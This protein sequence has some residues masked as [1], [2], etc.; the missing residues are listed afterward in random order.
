MGITAFDY[1]QSRERE[2]VYAAKRDGRPLGMTSGKYSV[3]SMSLKMLRDSWD[4]LS[5]Q[6]TATGLGSYGDA[7]FT[8]I[9]QYIEPLQ[10]PI[11]VTCVGCRIKG[12]KP[13]NEEGTEALMTELDIQ[14]LEI[15]EN[16]KPL[17]SLVR[18]V[19]L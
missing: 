6:L 17:A 15:L 18:A 5:T 7:E 13:S 14:C 19:P 2:V 4:I 11:T 1:E 12:V 10:L 3:P 8:F 16:G 9:A